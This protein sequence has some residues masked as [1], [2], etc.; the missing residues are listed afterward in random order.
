MKRVKSRTRGA[1]KIGRWATKGRRKQK[2]GFLGLIIAGLTALGMS[3]ASAATA[4][5]VAAPIVTGAI[6]G[7]ASYG[8]SK[9]LGSGIRRGRRR[10]RIRH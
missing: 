3:A 4:A 7:A 5:A 2:G 1:K 10:R 8:M 9:A 6:S